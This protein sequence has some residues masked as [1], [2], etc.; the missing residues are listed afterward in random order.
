MAPPPSHSQAVLPN[1]VTLVLEKIERSEKD[2]RIFVRTHQSAVC[3]GCHKVSTSRHSGYNR[4]LNDLP[5]QGLSVQIWLNVSRYRCRNIA[6]TRKIF[7]ERMPGVARVYARQTMRLSEIIG[8]VG[9]IAGGLPG[10]RLLDRLAIKTSD[11]TIRRRVSGN[12]P[13]SQEQQPIRHL[14]VDDWAWR[15]HQSYGTILVDLT[16]RRVADLLPDRSAESLSVWLARHPTVEV[17]TRDRCGLYAEGASE[18]APAAVQVADRFHLVLN[19][20][21]AIERVLEERS[22]QLV[23]SP[24]PPPPAEIPTTTALSAPKPTIQQVA[25]QQRR[26]R[27]LDRYQQVVELYA[28]GCSKKMISREIDVG[29]KTVRR[30]LRAGQ[31]PERK[32]PSGRRQRAAAFGDYLQQRWSEGCHNATQLYREIRSRGYKGCRAMVGQ[33]VSG[34]RKTG[35]QLAKTNAPERIAPKHAAILVARAPDSITKE[36][37]SL[38]DR[39]TIN[40]PDLIRLRRIAM[41]FREALAGDDG[42]VLRTWIDKVK[43]CEFGPLVRFGYGLQKDIAAVTAAVETDWSNGQVEGQI[44]RLKAIKRQMYGRAGF[45]LLRARVLPYYSPSDTAGAHPP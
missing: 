17:I 8:V 21:A 29:Y 28:K 34:W 45:N 16:R 43:H 14:G 4:R 5:W 26:Q 36:Q 7:C 13:E 38:L 22:R 3:P 1:P 19:L 42:V 33:F 23:L 20:S 6:C 40:C 11:D 10:A 15:K 41:A 44:N 9:Y 2:F 37:Q 18:G 25:Q 32:S 30:W 24:D 27:R 39:L 12:R 35:R 31:F